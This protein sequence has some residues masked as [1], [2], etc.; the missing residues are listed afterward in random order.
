M[1]CCEEK[2]DGKLNNAT[3]TA[4]L[5]WETPRFQLRAD[6]R[7]KASLCVECGPR[8]V[9]S[10]KDDYVGKLHAKPQPDRSQASL[11]TLGPTEFV[12]VFLWL[13]YELFRL[14]LTTDLATR[15]A[16]CVGSVKAAA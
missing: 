1:Q 9:R 10:V 4:G 15:Y 12:T 8:K 2:I 7:K 3:P 11:V 6:G 16:Q 14:P 5:E 13:C